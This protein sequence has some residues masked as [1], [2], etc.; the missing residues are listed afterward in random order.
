MS[1]CEDLLRRRFIAIATDRFAASGSYAPLDV[2]REVASLREWLCDSALARRQFGSKG[3]E[4]LE[5]RPRYDDIKAQL[6]GAGFTVADAVVLY[7]TG[8]G[9][10]DKGAHYTVLEQSDPERLS[11]TAL[12]TMEL[13]RWLTD[14]RDLEHVLLV[15][16]LCH[17]GDVADEVPAALRQAVPSQWMAL[18]TTAAGTDAKLGAFTGAV[19]KVLAELRAGSD[20]DA[21]DLEAHLQSDVFIRRV[22]HV[23][24]HDYQQKLE[25]LQDPYD[26]S[27]CLP[28]PRYDPSRH[29]RVET[30]PARRD[31][32][33]LKQDM[34]AHWGPRARVA[35]AVDGAGWLFTG[36]RRLVSQLIEFTAGPRGTLVVSGRAGSGKSAVLARLVTCSD[37]TFRQEHGE[38]L[39]RV[40][41]RASGRRRGYRGAGH[42]QDLRADRRT[43]RWGARRRRCPSSGQEPTGHVDR[44]HLRGGRG[45]RDAADSGP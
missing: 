6:T 38:L 14:Y 30:A 31:L 33:V 43:D 15:I 26:F 25:V 11:S 39:G 7:V 22:R 40:Q 10:T 5:Q 12:S 29:E 17:A 41:P 8:H 21:T 16:D 2:G 35:P 27:C 24:D 13:L 9:Q 1:G 36:R 28:N 32:A 44:G 20:R 18:L 34:T 45:P 19:N 3:F 23:M 42:R 37:S 4:S